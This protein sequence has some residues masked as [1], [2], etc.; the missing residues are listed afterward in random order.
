M[1]KQS[2]DQVAFARGTYGFSNGSGTATVHV[3]RDVM[4]SKVVPALASVIDKEVT[5]DEAEQRSD[6]SEAA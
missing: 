5:Y 6:V 3:P 2:N 1:L 4:A